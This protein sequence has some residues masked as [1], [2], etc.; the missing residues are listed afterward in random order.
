MQCRR[1]SAPQRGQQRVRTGII[2]ESPAH[3]GEPVHI[4][5]S[6]DKA[7][8]ELKRVPAQA[9]LAVPGGSCAVSRGFVFGPKHVENIGAAQARG[10]VSQPVLVY[11][12]REIDAGLFPKEPRVGP[13]TQPYCGQIRTPLPERLLPFAQLR[14]M[15][16]AEE[17]PIVPEEDHDGRLAFPKRAKADF[18]ALF[19][20]QGDGRERLAQRA[21]HCASIHTARARLRP[22]EFCLFRSYNLE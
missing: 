5:R 16:P 14:D 17:S 6:E 12:K 11:Q 22:F 21:G 1:R 10:P 7:P 15:L 2:A 20:G 3:V 4:A 18:P 9:V 8:A 19:V 13:I